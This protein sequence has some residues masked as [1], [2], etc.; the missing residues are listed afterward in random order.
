[1]LVNVLQTADIVA[2]CGEF[3]REGGMFG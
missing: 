1:M 2:A 3:L